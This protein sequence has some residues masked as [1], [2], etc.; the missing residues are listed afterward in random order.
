MAPGSREPH[1]GRFKPFNY[2]AT[3][4]APLYRQVMLAFVAAKRRFV[5][6]LRSEDV[7]AELTGDGGADPGPVAE[8]LA[9]LVE[10]G[11]LRA[12]PDT[13][14]VTTV[15][16]F[17]RAR[18]LYQLTRGGEA[19]ERALVAYDEHLG[20]RGALQAVALSDI[21]LQ[22]RALHE[23]ARQPRPDGARVALLLRDLV[24]RCDDLAENAQAFMASMQRTIDLHDAD[25]EA[26]RAYK[27]R[28]IDYLERFIKDLVT[29]GAEIA[30]LLE[31]M[32]E[33]EVRALLAI[34][35]RRDAEDVAPG[36]AAQ[37]EDPRAAA[38]EVEL[39]S[40]TDRWFG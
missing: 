23:L 33:A 1:S 12:D 13:S 31:S 39:A 37:G 16:D 11:N 14:R 24:G 40:W 18:F 2:L 21:A 10:W 35:A 20:R 29:V 22:L 8:A 32:D 27:D 25:P 15:E 17:H 26:F 3:Q 5:V 30:E 9:K 4:N 6:H 7:V 36:H 34:A 19:A 38:F 28:L